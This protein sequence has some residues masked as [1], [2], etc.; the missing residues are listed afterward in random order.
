MFH[1]ENSV[2]TYDEEQKIIAL[3]VKLYDLELKEVIKMT[4]FD[5]L[6]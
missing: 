1:T 3:F 4:S 5:L 6:R 2:V